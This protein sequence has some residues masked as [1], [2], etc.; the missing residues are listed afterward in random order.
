MVI[1]LESLLNGGID[2]LPLD[3]SFDFSKEEFNGVF[4][5]TTPVILKGKIIN[6]AGVVTINATADFV[7]ES[8]C[9]RCAGQ[10]KI[11]YS[12]PI[13]HTIVSELSNEEDSDDYIVVENMKL[14][15]EKLTLEDIY[16]FLPS[17][18]LCSEECKGI[19]PQCGTNLNEKSC[20]CKKPIDPRFE[21]LLSLLD[22]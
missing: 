18:I 15:L 20:D 17:K 2:E 1:A 4:P 12:T 16:L 9:D 5:F 21:A 14:D 19:C 10:A 13:E 22:E 3:C 7:F 6:R 11:K 8:V